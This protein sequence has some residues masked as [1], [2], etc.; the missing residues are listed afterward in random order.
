MPLPS[1]RLS[2]S[3]IPVGNGYTY[4]PI[5]DYTAGEACIKK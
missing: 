3:C 2:E 1:N 5:P 4:P